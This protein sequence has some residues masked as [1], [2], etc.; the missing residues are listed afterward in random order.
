MGNVPKGTGFEHLML[1]NRQG[2]LMASEVVIH[3]RDGRVRRIIPVHFAKRGARR[4]A[5]GIKIGR[6]KIDSPRDSDVTCK[7][8]LRA[9]K[10]VD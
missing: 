5:C 3:G 9:R 6:T 10:V 8:C 2:D 7:N 1:Y 4:T